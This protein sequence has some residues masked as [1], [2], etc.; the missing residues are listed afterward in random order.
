MQVRQYNALAWNRTY[1]FSLLSTFSALF[2]RF[3]NSNKIFIGQFG[4]STF[5]WNAEEGC[6]QAQT[7]N[8]YTFPR[9]YG[10]ADVR[11]TCQ[12]WEVGWLSMC[13]CVILRSWLIPHAPSLLGMVALIIPLIY[14]SCSRLPLWTFFASMVLTSTSSSTQVGIPNSWLGTL[15]YGERIANCV[16]LYVKLG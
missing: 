7:F 8:F 9:P 16:I 6:Y 13:V 10:A 12:V 14:C 5:H 4:L 1:L 11:F 3:L 2:W 15:I